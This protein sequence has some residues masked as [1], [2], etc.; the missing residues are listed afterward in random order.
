MTPLE[1]RL[2][3]RQSNAAVALRALAAQVRAEGSRYAPVLLDLAAALTMPLSGGC[4]ICGGALPA[5]A[6]TGRPR[7]LCLICSPRRKAENQR[8]TGR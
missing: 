4:R 5:S 6:A 3:R 7:V 1:E 2:V 8:K